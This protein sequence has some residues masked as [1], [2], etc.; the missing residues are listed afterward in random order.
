MIA[1]GLRVASSLIDE[2]L[3]LQEAKRQSVTAT[4]DEIN[5]ALEQIEKQN[6]MKSGG[7]NEFM[8]ARGIAT[9]RGIE[10]E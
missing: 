1:A 10:I 7:L 6:N 8:K 4:D 9:E 3:Q 5:K 2:K